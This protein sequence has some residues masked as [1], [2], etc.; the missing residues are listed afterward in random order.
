MRRGFSAPN[1]ERRFR[2]VSP[3]RARRVF[4]LI[5][6]IRGGRRA[7]YPKLSIDAAD[8]PG[9]IDREIPGKRR[10]SFRFPLR[11]HSRISAN[12]SPAPNATTNAFIA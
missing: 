11:N 5:F 12:S 1:A 3:L 6:L 2:R 9:F 8:E 10:V 7:W 4:P